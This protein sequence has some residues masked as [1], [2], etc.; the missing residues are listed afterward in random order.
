MEIQDALGAG[1]TVLLPIRN[2][3]GHIPTRKDDGV[4]LKYSSLPGGD[5]VPYNLGQT[6]THDA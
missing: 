2:T 1:I 3:P 4:L 6:L 5:A